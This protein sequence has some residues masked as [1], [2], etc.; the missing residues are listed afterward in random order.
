MEEELGERLFNLQLERQRKTDDYQDERRRREMELEKEEQMGQMDM[1]RQAQSIRQEREQ[2][3]HDRKMDEKKQ[4]QT[5]EMDK[6]NIYA[7]M[8]A[9]QIMVANPSITPE[10]AQAM[11]EK[12]KAEAAQIERD[13]RADDAKE[14]T[15]MMK[16]FMEQQMQAVRDMSSAN[17][18][19]M[20]GMM[21]SK[22]REIERTQQ[23]ADKNEDRYANVVREQ[24][25][26]GNKGKVKVCT[27]CGQEVGD[28]IF[29]PECGTRQGQE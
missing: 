13:T 2:A 20:S 6:L 3:E 12:F 29:C 7:G 11:A 28:E 10:A 24:I 19:A 27:N 22:E 16:E 4:D 26:S 9:E 1:L 23:M 14:Q 21:E 15:R 8:S 18:Q 25:K 17:A 5:H